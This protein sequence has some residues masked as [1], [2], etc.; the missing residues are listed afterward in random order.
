MQRLGGHRGLVISLLLV[1]SP[2]LAAQ[3]TLPEYLVV[4]HREQLNRMRSHFHALRDPYRVPPKVKIVIEEFDGLSE[5]NQYSWQRDI[6]VTIF[7]VGEDASQNNP[8]HNHSSSW[9]P[10]WLQNYGGVD[11]PSNRNG[12]FPAGFKPRQ[13]PF[14]I[15]LPYN[16]VQRGGGR[17][18]P[19]ASSLIKWFWRSAKAPG[20]SV[21]KDRWLAIHY[22]HKVCYAQWKDC[23]PF[24]TDDHAYVFQGK[25][26]KPNRNGNA[27]L[28]ISPAVRDFL[29]VKSSQMVSWKFVENEDVPQG[30]WESW[31]LSQG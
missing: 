26:P 13:N 27:G 21:C 29:G 6:P 19:E 25:R 17:F 28:D 12:F 4:E 31:I 7:W 18:K 30:P 2:I 14:Y 24:Y 10:N 15:A 20:K 23:G 11:D 5:R 16:D 3:M 22:G 9:E 1:L 8:T